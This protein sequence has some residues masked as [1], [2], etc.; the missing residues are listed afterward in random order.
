MAPKAKI[1]L[2]LIIILSALAYA[3]IAYFTPRSQFEQLLGLL[4]ITFAGYFYLV[5]DKLTFNQGLWIAIGFRL[6]FL[7]AYPRLSDD[8]FRFVWDGTLLVNGEN[9][10][11]HLPS[12]YLQNENSPI[13]PGLM[14]SFY[15]RLNSPEY[16]SVYPPVC[17][18]FFGLASYLAG[19][20]FWLNSFFLRL[21]ILAGELGSIFYLTRILHFLR[22]PQGQIWSYALNPLIIIELTGNLH[23]E[24]WLIFFLLG[25]F[26]LLLRA[27]PALSAVMLGL[28]V[29]VK[30]WPLLFMPFIW[31]RLSFKAFF[32]YATVVLLVLILIFSPFV[33]EVLI[34]N[35]F[36]S[37]N[38]YFQKFEFNASVY[39][40]F[41]WLG[42]Q[43]YGY[44]N[45]ARFGP[46]LSL[47]TLAGI[48]YL[49]FFQKR[50]FTYSHRQW[51]VLLLVG[52]TLYL[53]MA[54]VVHPWYL[55]TLVALAT[56][57]RWRYP[58]VWSGLAFLSYATYQTSAYTE[59]LWLV[60]LEYILLYSF[61]IYEWRIRQPALHPNLVS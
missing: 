59:N 20:S 1:L 13:I 25:S 44:N 21:L 17:Q 15:Q 28:A 51:W 32:R 26:Y 7:I 31:R 43:I 42:Y 19:T 18:A 30:L 50:N 60:A 24:A 3:G 38:L 36:N 40:F 12:Y 9:P 27:R 48:L 39:Y 52:F 57:T 54:T 46:L 22:F 6:V 29:G 8:Y 16:Y 2:T 61:I 34:H 58:M 55:T 33:S 5:R 14:E 45:I 56:C 41:R 4:G 47:A 10:Y 11:L 35:I 23:P 49:A 53:A 37:L